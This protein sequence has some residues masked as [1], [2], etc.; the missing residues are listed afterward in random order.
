MDHVENYLAGCVSSISPCF[1]R[2]SCCQ[3]AP[4]PCWSEWNTLGWENAGL[5][6]QPFRLV[7]CNTQECVDRPRCYRRSVGSRLRFIVFKLLFLAPTRRYATGSSK[8]DIKRFPHKPLAS[9]S[10][11]A[12]TS[13]WTYLSSEAVGLVLDRSDITGW[14]EL[15]GILVFHPLSL[16]VKHSIVI[17]LTQERY[18]QETFLKRP[19]SYCSLTRGQGPRHFLVRYHGKSRLS[20]HIELNL[21]YLIKCRCLASAKAWFWDISGLVYCRLDWFQE[22]LCD[23]LGSWCFWWISR[24]CTNFSIEAQETLFIAW[25]KT[26]RK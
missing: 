14:M 24:S 20:V 10:L 25:G 2:W 22:E 1:L 8:S 23:I 17:I 9:G 19:Q 18:V 15:Q 26:Q 7:L 6:G 16:V 21:D 11:T 12:C 5:I 13:V 4:K 3:G